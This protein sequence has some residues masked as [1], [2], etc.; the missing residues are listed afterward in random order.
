MT[1]K[2][3]VDDERQTGKPPKP[4]LYVLAFKSQ[5]LVEVIGYYDGRYWG[6]A[7]KDILE[8]LQG[9]KVGDAIPWYK[10]CWWKAV[11]YWRT[12]TITHEVAVEAVIKALGG[13]GSPKT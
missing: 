7:G 3:I 10:R 5:P 11:D 9:L 2:I 1:T 4:G 13:P 12:M 6:H 8:A